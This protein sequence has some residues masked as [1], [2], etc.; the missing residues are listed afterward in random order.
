MLQKV[1][2]SHIEKTNISHKDSHFIGGNQ[3]NNVQYFEYWGELL[4]R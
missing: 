4:T 2:K 3:T 1:F